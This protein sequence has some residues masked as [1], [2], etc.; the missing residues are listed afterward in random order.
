MTKPIVRHAIW[1][2]DGTLFDTYPPL[3]RAFQRAL[4]DFGA[5]VPLEEIESLSRVEVLHCAATLANRFALDQETFLR[6]F[7]KHY[8]AV[9]FAEQPPFPHARE[10]CEKIV[11]GGGVNAI[12]THRNAHSTA[13]LLAEHGMTALFAETITRDDGYPAKPDPAAFLAILQ[14]QGLDPRETLAIG[15]R[16]IDILAGQAAGTWTCLFRGGPS[17]VAPDLAITDYAEL[18][19]W[20]DGAGRSTPGT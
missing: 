13:G 17:G 3:N 4:A 6:T 11:A 9:P 5:F 8:M 12:V 14:H 15:D 10:V 16:E 7:G 19:A 1:D 18:L 2:L 20:L